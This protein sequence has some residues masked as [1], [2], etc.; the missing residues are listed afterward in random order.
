MK[1]I[2]CEVGT[3]LMSRTGS[4]EI[5]IPQSPSHNEFISLYHGV[6]VYRNVYSKS[7]YKVVDKLLLYNYNSKIL[8]VR[9]FGSEL[10][11]LWSGS[12][13]MEFVVKRSRI[14]KIEINKETFNVVASITIMEDE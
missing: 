6:I 2:G 5:E 10:Q 3:G 11:L 14:P 4:K 7:V 1:I 13:P 8:L 9:Q 12:M